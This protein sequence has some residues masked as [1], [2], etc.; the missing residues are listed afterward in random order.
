MKRFQATENAYETLSFICSGLVG[1][2]ADVSINNY[3]VTSN[4]KSQMYDM[5]VVKKGDSSSDQACPIPAQPST[6][7]SNTTTIIIAVVVV[8]AVVLVIILIIIFVV[9]QRRKNHK[10]T[11]QKS[12]YEST[13]GAV[14]DKT[15]LSTVKTNG[16][17]LSAPIPDVVG[18]KI[19]N[20]PRGTD[21]DIEGMDNLSYSPGILENYDFDKASSIAQSDTHDYLQYY[22][23]LRKNKHNQQKHS[24]KNV[25]MKMTNQKAGIRQSPANVQNKSRHSPADSSVGKSRASPNNVLLNGALLPHVLLGTS[26]DAD[27][28][29][30][31]HHVS[32]RRSTPLSS[33]TR[34]SGRSDDVAALRQLAAA[35]R[36]K[37]V[38]P[39][40]M[41]AVTQPGLSV[42]MVNKLNKLQRPNA[43]ID[44]GDM[45]DSDS[46]MN[47]INTTD[48]THRD[49][50]KL[51]TMLPN[52]SSSE[53]NNSNDSFTC[54]EFDGDNG[55]MRID[56]R[57]TNLTR[58]LSQVRERSDSDTSERGKWRDNAS[59]ISNSNTF[60][61][62][63]AGQNQPAEMA[64]NELDLERLITWKPAY[65]SFAGVL[66]DIGLLADTGKIT[67]IMKTPTPSVNEM[68]SPSNGLFAGHKAP[69]PVEAKNRNSPGVRTTP[70]SNKDAL[71]GRPLNNPLE[72][73]NVVR[74]TPVPQQPFSYS[75]S[76]NNRTISSG[77]SSPY[78]T[79]TP[80]REMQQHQPQQIL[81]HHK[82]IRPDT[83]GY[84]KN[85]LQGISHENQLSDDSIK[86]NILSGPGRPH[87][88]LAI[89]YASNRE[90]IATNTSRSY[91]PQ[92]GVIPRNI[93]AA[94]NALNTHV[95][96]MPTKSLPQEKFYM[97]R[98][99][100]PVSNAPYLL[101]P[102][103]MQNG[104]VSHDFMNGGNSYGTSYG[105][106]SSSP[107]SYMANHSSPSSP[108]VSLIANHNLSSYNSNSS[109]NNQI[110]RV[111]SPQTI[112]PLP[113][114]LIEDI[115]EDYI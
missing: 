21:S 45:N 110:E 58:S 3:S 24:Y 106:H 74:L 82:T 78:Q 108:P 83:N 8:V 79:M 77:A 13:N 11:A 76:D 100:S 25:A 33:V 67:P 71:P 12:T 49:I 85:F 65:E 16:T 22:S 18:E 26:S 52:D 32:S 70:L 95:N 34:T 96:P 111:Y 17:S 54:S 63:F 57:P 48:V 56:N 1:C 114:Q 90:P 112:S 20:Q 68:S 101:P 91:T 4:S 29:T 104:N 107:V 46:A 5:T 72:Q 40:K 102:S 61:T 88:V 62:L 6:S 27:H 51:S 59:V 66:A 38:S 103:L 93:P 28:N 99:I 23:G 87:S 37:S 39:A 115:H 31:A 105:G 97:Q 41:L 42:D 50:A 15:M 84:N 30:T 14:H 10:K 35:S 44:D 92:D 86:H 98:N 113:H 60:D 94:Y 55:P 109:Y 53:D 89:P 2:L 7:E 64:T 75:S 47:S 69:T 9:C 36:P 73:L 81:V 80:T 43:E 19:C